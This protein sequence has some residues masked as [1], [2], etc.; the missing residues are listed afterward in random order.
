MQLATKLPLPTLLVMLPSERKITMLL[1]TDV[2]HARV[3]MLTLL[4]TMLLR[5]TLSVLLHVA[6]TFTLT[7]TRAQHALMAMVETQ[8]TIQKVQTPCATTLDCVVTHRLVVSSVSLQTLKGVSTTI[9]FVKQ[10]LQV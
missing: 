9:A 8:V 6:E 2:N 4:E 10:V 7:T 5:A 1:T 3:V